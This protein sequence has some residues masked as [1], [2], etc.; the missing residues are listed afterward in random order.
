MQKELEDHVLRKHWKAIPLNFLPPNKRPL[1][2]VWSMKRKHNRLGEIN[3]WK[4]RLCAGGHKSIENVNYWATYSPVVSRSAVRLILVLELINNWTMRSI[5]FVMAFPQAHTKTDIYMKP[6]TVPSNFV[7]PDLPKFM[8]RFTHV[9][10]LIKKLYGLKD[11]GRTW[12]KF[13]HKGLLEC[14]WKQSDIDDCLFTQ[15]D[16]LLL[17]YVD[18]AILVSKSNNRIEAEI[19]SLKSSFGITEKGP[20]KD[21]L[22]T[23]FDRNS[24]GS[25]ELTQHR[26]IQRAVKV[27]GLDVNDRHVKMHNYPASSEKLLDNDPNGKPRLQPWHYRSAVD[28]LSYIS[29]MIRPDI[30]MPVQQCIP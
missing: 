8:D 16:I 30:N 23:R 28:F 4:A 11:V 24:D 3:K 9:Y 2:M 29:A 21:Y 17:L 1:P 12:H 10:K 18:D 6:P 25:I 27:I 15:R 13:L 19:R 14:N 7:I 26:M 20:L 22:G 5:D